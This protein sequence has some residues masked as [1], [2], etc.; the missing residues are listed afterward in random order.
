MPC[1]RSHSLY[2]AEATGLPQCSCHRPPDR[3]LVFKAFYCFLFL[4]CFLWPHPSHI[5]APRLGVELEPHQIRAKSVTY[6]AAHANAGSL[7]HILMDIML[8]S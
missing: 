7:S 4:F 3:L 6:T 1:P 8:G 2:V 5:E